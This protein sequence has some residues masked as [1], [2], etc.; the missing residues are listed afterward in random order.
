MLG[1]IKK[2]IKIKLFVIG[3][4]AFLWLMKKK[5]CSGQNEKE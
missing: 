2:I 3:L 1:L 4:L 5:H